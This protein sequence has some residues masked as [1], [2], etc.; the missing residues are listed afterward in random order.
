MPDTIP[1][2]LIY[3]HGVSR[4]NR[5]PHQPIYDDL[6]NGVRAVDTLFP[7][8]NDWEAAKRCYV[9]WG[10]NYDNHLNPE[11]DHL[12]AEAQDQFADKILSQVQAA[13]DSTINPL[14]MF[15]S[16]MRELMIKGF[17]DMFYYASRD[18]KSSIRATVASQI[19][20]CIHDPLERGEPISLTLLGHS[21]GSVVAF[22]FLFYLFAPQEILAS[23]ESEK[24]EFIEKQYDNINVNSETRED[25]KK[26]R[27]L[28]EQ[29]K[30]RVRRLITFGSPISMLAFR[31][32]A[33]LEILAQGQQLNPSHYGLDQNPAVFGAA[34]DGPRWI[35]FWDKDDIIAW[36]VQFLMQ[37]SPVVADIYTDV[38]DRITTVHNKYWTS[39]V[40]YKEIAAHW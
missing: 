17:S 21:A 3:I 13:K 29:Q 1:E 25:F 7:N 16:P 31:S 38:A 12:L 23:H 8:K 27:K 9:E 33:V 11:G 14:R 4:D 20:R 26:L 37:D 19:M 40:V 10:W 2:Y 32:N 39:K 18:G 35:N 22:D 6:H 24:R 28:A 5:Q 30:L 15:L 34:L 36:P